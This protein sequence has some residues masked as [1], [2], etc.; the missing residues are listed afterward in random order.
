[1]NV[2][3]DG[4]ILDCAFD[5]LSHPYRRRVV[6]HLDNQECET[7]VTIGELTTES[8]TAEQLELEL[9][10]IHLP[11]LEDLDYIDWNET[12]GTIQR[13][14]RFDEIASIFRLLCSAEDELPGE[15]F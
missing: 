13:G 7:E 14:Q 5:A 9:S 12:N 8:E 15:L 4:Q 1:M 3:D 6:W 10:H 2:L 11:K